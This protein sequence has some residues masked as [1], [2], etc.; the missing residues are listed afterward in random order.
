MLIK[1]HAQQFDLKACQ[2]SISL[3][4]FDTWISFHTPMGIDMSGAASGAGDDEMPALVDQVWAMLV[5]ELPVDTSAVELLGPSWLVET[6]R[7]WLLAGHFTQADLDQWAADFARRPRTLSM[8][9]DAP[10]QIQT[11]DNVQWPALTEYV[12]VGHGM[13]T[14][15]AFDAVMN[16]LTEAGF[17]RPDRA[18]AIMENYLAETG[19]VQTLP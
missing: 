10:I 3:P 2:A 5:E 19:V 1:T 9:L 7:V 11:V 18:N 15:Q 13:V 6:R 12:G 8:Y 16:A 17:G 14:R 4:R